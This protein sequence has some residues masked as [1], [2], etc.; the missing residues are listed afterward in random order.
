MH[1]PIKI[2]E[3]SLSFGEKTCFTDF[4]YVIYPGEKIAII[5]DNGS[6]KSSL[7]NAI[8]ELSRDLHITVGYV[9]QIIEDFTTL[10]GGQRFNKRLSMVLAS[11]P[12]ILLLDEPTN[13]LDKDN[14]QSLM[15]LLKNTSVTQI[16]A[17]HDV[18]LLNH[19]IDTLWHIVN[20]QIRVIHG[21]YADYVEQL[22][23]EKDA[24]AYQITQL[25]RAKKEQH[26][27]LMTEQERRKKKKAHGEKKYDGDK[28][29]LRSAQGRGQRTA[30]K[31]S[32]YLNQ[33]KTQINDQWHQLWQPEDIQYAFDFIPGVD[34]KSVVNIQ[35]G[36]CGYALP[37]LLQNIAFNLSGGDR[38]ALSGSNGSGKSLLVK[39]IL[40]NST[41]Q[42]TGEWHVP[43]DNDIAYLDQHYSALPN[44]KTV[45][46]Y[47]ET[48][49]PHFTHAEWRHF[50]NQFLFRKNDEVYRPIRFL[51]GGEKARLSL[52]AIALKRPKL[53][54]LDEV[55]NNIDLTTKTHITQIL[56]TYSGALLIIS[57]EAD[58]I[59]AIDVNEVQDVRQWH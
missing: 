38:V 21:K 3:F 2:V 48:L 8:A 41:V 9:P 44:D 22:Q 46:G 26:E 43:A 24:L 56:K 1:T 5:G 33:V 40:G 59:R 16:I 58:F 54:I 23:Q 27:A 11:S 31:N 49:E 10:S 57:H 29:A 37:C 20:G 4:H 47:L 7:L 42:R 18:E 45:I 28:I 35:E 15:R 36:S 52:A 17:S 12:C 50:L 55:T 39:A 14:R 30:N 53:L 34:K 32:A 13:H 6:G 25:K 51:S 19:H